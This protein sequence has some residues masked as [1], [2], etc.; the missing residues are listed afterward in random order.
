M[1]TLLVFQV[2]RRH[3]YGKGIRSNS[4]FFSFLLFQSSFTTFQQ[5]ELYSTFEKGFSSQIYFFNGFSQPPLLRSKS[6][7]CEKSFVSMFPNLLS[8][9][10]RNLTETLRETQ[11]NTMLF[12][13]KV[14]LRK[15]ALASELFVLRP[16]FTRHL[17]VKKSTK[18]S[19][20]PVQFIIRCWS[21]KPQ[22]K[23]KI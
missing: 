1:T 3:W 7:S 11:P 2:L 15:F 20:L 16:Y 18:I 14:G 9:G 13:S 17:T 12:F 23:R 10:G 22:L 4:Q 5:L 8:W 6:A 21:L 19:W